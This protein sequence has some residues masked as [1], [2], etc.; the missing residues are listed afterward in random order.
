MYVCVCVYNSERSPF[1]KTRVII[2]L[3]ILINIF[4]NSCICI[5]RLERCKF[6][7]N[8]GEDVMRFPHVARN[9]QEILWST[10]R[11]SVNRRS[12]G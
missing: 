8:S 7:G 5:K 6:L 12:D 11:R 3:F 2:T 10:D 4:V 1:T 9:F